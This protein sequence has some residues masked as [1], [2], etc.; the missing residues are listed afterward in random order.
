MTEAQSSAAHRIARAAGIV[1]AAFV[2]SNLAGLVKWILV[3]HAFGTGIEMDAFNAANR[4]PDILFQLMAGG[5][6]ASAFIPT[7]TALL[8]NQDRPAAW[9]LASSI[10]N[11][12]FLGLSLAAVLAWLSTGWLVRHVLAPGFTDPAQIALTISLM[13]ILLIS[14]VAF[15]LSGLLMGVLNAHQHF[16]LPAL[17]PTLFWLGWIFGVLFLVPRWGIRGL[18]WGVVLGSLMHLAI[19]LPGLRGRQARYQLGLGLNDPSVRRVGALMAP[20]VLGVAVVQLN[21]LVNTILASGQPEGSLT[22]ITIAFAVMMMPQV[23]IAQSIGIAALPTFSAQAARM[24]LGELRS[25]LATT[26]RGVLFLSLPACLGLILLRQPI[27]AMLFQGGAFGAHSTDLVA[28]ALLWY[29]AGLVAHSALEIVARAFYAMQDTRTPVIVGT[30]AM[31]L[32]VVLS[33]T[34][35]QAFTRIGWAPHGGLALAN[36]AATAVECLTLLWLLRRRLA[37]LGLAAVRRGV[38]ATLAA[39]CVMGVVLAGWADA[40]S[41]TPAWAVG[42]G[43]VVIG[44]AI[45]WAIALMLGAPE[46]RQLPTMVLSRLHR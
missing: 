26:L 17:A 45:Y 31:S 11:L 42:L 20:R 46:A 44:G 22:G 38:L 35:A 8:E 41:A 23:I 7:F 14:A 40:L 28:W 9:R 4:L 32:N 24:E 43:G 12:V 37:G 36:S 33:L 15:G 2:I 18:A 29:A 27:V 19:Q 25:T 16:L 21:F 1:M 5:A 13:R 10:A 30:L 3:S 6:L 34:L 39:S